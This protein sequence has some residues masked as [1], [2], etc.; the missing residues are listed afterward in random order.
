LHDVAVTLLAELESSFDVKRVEG[1]GLDPELEGRVKL[2]RPSVRLI[3]TDPK[4]APLTVVFTAFPGLLVRAGHWCDGVFPS[5]GCDACA[6]T[7]EAETLRLRETIDDVVGGRF[8]ERIHLPVIGSAW[9]ASELWSGAGRHASRSRIDRD[10]ARAM[11]DK[12]EGSKFEWA[13]W[14]R[15]TSSR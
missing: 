11:I 6:E 2:A 8:S 12:A 10:R 1:Y 4:A 15:R 9:Q 14:P 7:A 5:C 13:S 3:P